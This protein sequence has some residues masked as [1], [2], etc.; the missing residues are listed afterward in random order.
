MDNN[1]HLDNSGDG[2]ANCRRH[3]SYCQDG[4]GQKARQEQLQLW[5]QRM[6]I[7]Y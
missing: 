3:S 1:K 5:L 2:G 6:S 4:E 7:Q